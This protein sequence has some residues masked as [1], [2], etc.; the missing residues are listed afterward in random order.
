[1][2]KNLFSDSIYFQDDHNSRP[3]K[4]EDV[5]ALGLANGGTRALFFSNPLTFQFRKYTIPRWRVP[6]LVSQEN[7]PGAALPGFGFPVEQPEAKKVKQAAEAKE[8]ELNLKV[9]KVAAREVKIDVTTNFPDDTILSVSVYRL[10]DIKYVGK[11]FD[12]PANVRKGKVQ[13]TVPIMDSWHTEYMANQR[14]LGKELFSD[15]III[16]D[17]VTVRVGY[18]PAWQKNLKIKKILGD[19]GQFVKGKGTEKSG[20]GISMTRETKI[21]IPFKK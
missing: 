8:Y 12:T 4:C 11:I 16:S 3:T 9:I 7:T 20:T 14:K 17:D 2:K 1:M 21:H 15:I 13:I 18:Y 19:K 5:H 10:Y 6:T